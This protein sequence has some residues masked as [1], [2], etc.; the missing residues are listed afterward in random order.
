MD[1]VIKLSPNSTDKP[2][3]STNGQPKDSRSIMFFWVRASG[4]SFHGLPPDGMVEER[5]RKV[6]C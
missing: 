6:S 4:D 5:P 2:S 3:F 1:P